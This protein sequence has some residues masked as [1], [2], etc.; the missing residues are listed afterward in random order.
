MN[1]TARGSCTYAR[2]SQ[3]EAAAVVYDLGGRRPRRR[4]T[5][6]WPMACYCPRCGAW[7]VAHESQQPVGG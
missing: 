4:E 3:V 1:A 7:H 5:T 6:G 2:F